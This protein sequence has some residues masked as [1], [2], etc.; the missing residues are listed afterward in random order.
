M[1]FHE[2]ATFPNKAD[3][4]TTFGPGF[5]TRVIPLNS[6]KE[7]RVQ[8]WEMARHQGTVAYGLKK[9]S[10]LEEIRE[11]YYARRGAAHGFRFR[12][13]SD[14]ISSINGVDAVTATDQ[15]LG[16][17]DGVVKVFQLQKRYADTAG[18]D[19]YRPVTKPVSG[20]VVVAL[21]GTPTVVGFAIDTT[22]GTI[23]FVTAPGAGVDVTAGFEFHVPCRF[24]EDFDE[25]MLINFDTHDVFTFPG[26]PIIEISG[27]EAAID[28]L[29]PGG[30]YVGDFTDIFNLSITLA[31]YYEL[32]PQ[33]VLPDVYLP[34]SDYLGGGGPYFDI[35]NASGVNS[36]RIRDQ[37]GTLL[38]TVAP[39]DL[40]QV[41]LVEQTSTWK[42]Y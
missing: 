30:S 14:Y 6:G 3:F 29:W 37:S 10:D 1:A 2:N 40:V 38:K 22:L 7:E 15:L 11:F 28:E 23:T 20:T 34:I 35:V 26:I 42:L 19:Y 17:G 32:D 39:G 27:E 36:F 13:P 21:G 24:G 18:Y 12:D 8:I 33:D 31:R 4:G 25:T 16:T 5:L 41:F 9:K